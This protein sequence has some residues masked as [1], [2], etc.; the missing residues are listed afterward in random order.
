MHDLYLCRMRMLRLG[1]CLLLAVLAIVVMA[2]CGGSSKSSSSIGTSTVAKAAS[3]TTASTPA[4]GRAKQRAAT[5]LGSPQFRQ[6]LTKFAT[7]MREN[8]VNF[9]APNRSG[10]GP[11]FS[12]K[13]VDTKSAA[14]RAA[15]TKCAAVLRAAFASASKASRPPGGA[16][17]AAGVPGSAGATGQAKPAPVVRP[18]VKVPPAIA[19]DLE[20]FTACMREHGVSNYPEPEGATFNTSHLHLD[21]KGAQYKA[22]EKKCEPI[23]QAAFAP[24]KQG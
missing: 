10:K 3:T 18:K 16:P 14:F 19:H 15:D 1:T 11:V 23:L 24:P 22:A 13:G 17:P 9:P 20:R 4:A 21:T 7:C 5:R 8:G 12:A 6:A 2:A